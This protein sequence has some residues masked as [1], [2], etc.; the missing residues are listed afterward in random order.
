MLSSKLESQTQESRV[1]D[2]INIHDHLSPKDEV[3]Y[4][5]LTP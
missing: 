2:L 3:V 4:N 5:E 1:S